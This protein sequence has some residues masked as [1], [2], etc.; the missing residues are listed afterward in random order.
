M[1]QL[2]LLDRIVRSTLM[3]ETIPLEGKTTITLTDIHTGK[4]ERIEHKNAVTPAISTILNSNF[5][6]A[7]DIYSLLPIKQFFAG[8]MCFTDP[9]VG[10]P[11]R[12]QNQNVNPLI[13]HAG[14]EAHATASTRSGNPNM[15]EQVITDTSIKQVWDWASN[16]GN[17]TINTVCLCPNTLG[18]YGLLPL[19]T[20]PVFW[21]S[22]STKYINMGS[23]GQHQY[24][25]RERAIMNPFE[26]TSATSCLSAFLD[27][28]TFEEITSKHD[29]LSF[30]ILRSGIDWSE[31]SSRTATI[32]SKTSGKAL[33]FYDD[34]YYYVA[35]VTSATTI[36]IDKIAR[37]DMTVTT[38]D[39]TLSD[40]S[41]YSGNLNSRVYNQRYPYDGVNLYLP[42]STAT[43]FYRI[44]L[45]TNDVTLLD[46]TVTTG[47]PTTRGK[48]DYVPRIAPVAVNEGLILGESY[49]INDDTVYEIT[50]PSG[51]CGSGTNYGMGEYGNLAFADASGL[52][53]LGYPSFCVSGYHDGYSGNIG[54]GLAIPKLMLTT[55]NVLEAAVTKST[56]KT[57]KIEYTL[58][59]T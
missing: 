46:G 45:S 7:S 4:R 42:D 12:P 50:L 30:G 37:T 51:L 54:Q 35:E 10:T 8:V 18:N 27:G 55:V 31:Q 47:I 34:T 40:V 26:I 29:Y 38:A 15:G 49:M 21:A 20:T 32:R 39:I 3:G 36:Q 14:D 43:K 57:M 9:I 44:N 53:G 1:S 48:T 58:T 6:G 5:S 11:T 2:G 52:T 23:G 13:A 25:E 16:Q 33:F 41:L 22:G 24:T 59:E 17:G 56:S 28:T 19:E